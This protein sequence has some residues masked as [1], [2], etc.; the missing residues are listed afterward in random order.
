MSYHADLLHQAQSLATREPRRPRQA[1]LRRAVSASYYALFHLLIEAATH[2]LLAGRQREHL[3]IILGR[4]FMHSKMKAT[5]AS[6]ASGS[7]SRKLKPALGTLP[8]QPELSNVANAFVDLQQARHEADYDL[9]RR[10]TRQE[11]M[12]LVTQSSDAFRDWQTVRG[13]TQADVFL[14][15]LLVEHFIQ[16]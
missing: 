16:G 10:F 6:F 8:V 5:A 2:R 13:S 9:S 11:T 3:R 12:D 1:S 14:V 15:G 7:V 4:A